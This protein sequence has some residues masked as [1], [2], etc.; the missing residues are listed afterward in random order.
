VATGHTADDQAETVLLRIL[1]GTGIAGLAGIRRHRQLTPGVS[2]VRPLLNVSRDQAREYVESLGQG[3]RDDRSNS[4]LRYTRNRVRHELLPHLADQYNPG[5]VDAL[6][7]LAGLAEGVQDV[8]A[9]LLGDLQTRCVRVD[10]PDQVTVDCRELA[11]V[12]RYLVRELLIA[13]W[14]QQGWPLQAMGYERWEQLADLACP[15]VPP[16][17]DWKRVFPGSICV[18]RDGPW[19]RLLASPAEASKSIS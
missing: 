4:D 9:S 1:R 7:R 11:S 5:V 2:L 17:T 8:V 19:L 10:S 6:T 12:S 13:V 14:Q 18:Q 15:A 3:Y 16:S